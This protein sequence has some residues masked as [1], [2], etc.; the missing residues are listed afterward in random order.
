MTKFSKQKNNI[1][2]PKSVFDVAITW[3]NKCCY[4]ALHGVKQTD[5]ECLL[6]EEN[7]ILLV[8]AAKVRHLKLQ[9]A[10]HERVADQPKPTMLS[11]QHIRRISKKRKKLHVLGGTEVPNSLCNMW[12]CIILLKES[13]RDALKEGNDFGL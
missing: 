12:A 11:R 8:C 3:C 10:N 9:D 1:K 7:S 2:C 13:S 5:F 4:T 6:V